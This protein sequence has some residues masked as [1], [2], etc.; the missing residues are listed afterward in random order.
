MRW[1]LLSLAWL[2]LEWLEGFLGV[3]TATSAVMIAVVASG[4][5]AL[6]KLRA[7]KIEK[8]SDDKIIFKYIFPN[9]REVIAEELNL[10]ETR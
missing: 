9:V 2:H 3:G 1:R 5:G 8:I 4:S 10:S 6:N 7:Y